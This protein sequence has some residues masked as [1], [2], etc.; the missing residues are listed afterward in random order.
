[1]SPQ[2][3]RLAKGTAKQQQNNFLV[4]RI[5]SASSPQITA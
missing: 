2:I 3:T 1:M 5:G 4:Q